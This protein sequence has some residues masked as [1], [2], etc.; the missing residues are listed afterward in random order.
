MLMKMNYIKSYSDTQNSSAHAPKLQRY[1]EE[2]QGEEQH[3]ENQHWEQ[4]LQ[5]SPHA[6]MTNK[7]VNRLVEVFAK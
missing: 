5:Y 7:N 1:R 2:E 6:G 3:G 4:Q